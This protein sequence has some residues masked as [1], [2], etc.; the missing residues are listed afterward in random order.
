MAKSF[1][2]LQLEAQQNMA[3]GDVDTW[4]LY[5]IYLNG[6]VAMDN[7]INTINVPLSA[8]QLQTGNS[9]PIIAVPAVAGKSIQ[10][11]AASLDYVANAGLLGVNDVQLIIDTLTQAQLNCNNNLNPAVSRFFSLL[12]NTGVTGISDLAPNKNLL[13]KT[14]ADSLL[15]TA[16]ATVNIFYRLI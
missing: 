14:N 1:K 6:A 12:N 16:T 8:V 10:V 13:I 5:Q 15:G 9:I 2:Q 7:Q 3:N 11:I 4:L